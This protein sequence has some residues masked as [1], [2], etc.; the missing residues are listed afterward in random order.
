MKINAILPLFFLLNPQS[1]WPV[2]L[3]AGWQAP[4]MS[5]LERDRTHVIQWDAK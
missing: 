2:H 4:G 5:G 3:V 1:D